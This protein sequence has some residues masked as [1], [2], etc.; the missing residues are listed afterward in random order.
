MNLH[1]QE[2][3]QTAPP[4]GGLEQTGY[5]VGA[6]FVG[7]DNLL[8]NVA[9][10][11][12]AAFG[13]EGK[14]IDVKPKAPEGKPGTLQPDRLP[15]PDIPKS[16]REKCEARAF[17]CGAWCVAKIKPTNILKSI[18][19]AACLGYCGVEAA[20]CAGLLRH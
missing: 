1:A 8:H 18:G 17:Q 5:G 6:W 12:P 10:K 4:C 14:P 3:P 15:Q 7:N 20:I 13:K 16:G 2:R 9:D 11:D 19:L